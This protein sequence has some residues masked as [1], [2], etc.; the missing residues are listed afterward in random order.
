MPN[1]SGAI[2]MAFV[3]YIWFLAVLIAVG[4]VVWRQAHPKNR[5]ERRVLRARAPVLYDELGHRKILRIAGREARADG[6]RRGGNKTIGLAQ[7]DPFGGIVATPLSRALALLE[8][9]G[10]HTHP[11]KEPTDGRLLA[12]A[13]AAPELFDVDRTHVGRF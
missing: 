1:E 8:T 4:A 6:D 9:K 11:S 13:S 5:T 7:R 3:L 12:A 10:Y 2:T